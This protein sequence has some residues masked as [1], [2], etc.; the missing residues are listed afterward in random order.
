MDIENSVTIYHTI[1]YEIVTSGYS[2]RF[3]MTDSKF[4]ADVT[5]KGFTATHHYN[6]REKLF[7]GLRQIFSWELNST[8]DYME[9]F[10]EILE[11][12][13][14]TLQ[15]E[16]KPDT[17]T[18]SV[19][20]I[21]E[22]DVKSIEAYLSLYKEKIHKKYFEIGHKP[23]FIKNCQK[24]LE[25]HPLSP[26]LYGIIKHQ[27]KKCDDENRETR[28]HP[29]G[30]EYIECDK[31]LEMPVKDLPLYIGYEFKSETAKNIFEIRLT[32]GE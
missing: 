17:H 19:I 13:I 8:E 28:G 5:K 29:Y 26:K 9:K 14:K 7:R 16:G 11:K 2:D 10:K 20:N 6:T 18:R 15:I 22:D 24:Q 1:N 32:K 31:F 25:N 21:S 23:E 27:L 30:Y 3:L 4:R 12:E